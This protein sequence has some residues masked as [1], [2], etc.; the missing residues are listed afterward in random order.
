MMMTKKHI[1]PMHH[2]L[3]LVTIFCILLSWHAYMNELLH[4]K[5]N[6]N[7]THSFLCYFISFDAADEY[8]HYHSN[9]LL[10]LLILVVFFWKTK[11]NLK[12]VIVELKQVEKTKKTKWRGRERKKE[13]KKEEKNSWRWCVSPWWR[14]YDKRLFKLERWKRVVGCLRTDIKHDRKKVRNEKR[15]SNVWYLSIL[16]TIEQ[17][18][19]SG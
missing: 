7:T 9:V 19:E 4:K 6:E 16:P 10:H 1:E 8:N 12:N 18:T 11:V 15:K 13:R 14:W 3:H 17:M 2:Y 5:K